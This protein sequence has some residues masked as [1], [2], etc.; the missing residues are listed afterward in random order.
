MSRI[1]NFKH[2]N[3]NERSNIPTELFQ[4]TK[5]DI[6]KAK[7]KMM[8]AITA[9]GKSRIYHSTTPEAAVQI[10]KNGFKSEFTFFDMAKPDNNSYG[11]Y[12]IEL[13]PRDVL[14]RLFI[15]PEGFINTIDEQPISDKF[16]AQLTPQE[17]I[18]TLDSYLKNK[19]LP[20]AQQYYNIGLD[21]DVLTYIWATSTTDAMS[22][23]FVKGKIPANLI[24]DHYKFEN[25]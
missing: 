22:W 2:F 4:I 15:D 18:D 7:Q 14:N 21:L 11:D 23:V 20:L 5:N 24:K 8:V 6:I 9:T 3:V 19:N 1:K 25:K 12:I 13:D 16:D 10:L 17:I